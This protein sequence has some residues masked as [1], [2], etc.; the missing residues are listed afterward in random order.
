MLSFILFLLELAKPT[1][2]GPVT[3][4]Q[5]VEFL[6]SQDKDSSADKME[7]KLVLASTLCATSKHL[8]S[9]I[10]AKEH[11]LNEF[12]AIQSNEL[13]VWKRKTRFWYNCAQ[14][15]SVRQYLADR[16]VPT[17]VFAT[18][19]KHFRPDVEDSVSDPELNNMMV[20]FISTVATGQPKIEKDIAAMLK[21][22]LEVACSNDGLD[23]LNAIVVPL[24][25]SEETVPVTV[26]IE[27][28][29]Q[30]KVEYHQIYYKPQDASSENK[31][32]FSSSILSKSQENAMMRM[33]K[34]HVSE[35]HDSYDKLMQKKWTLIAQDDS[36][37]KGDF[38]K[39]SD[40]ISEKSNTLHLIK[41]TIN[42][43]SAVFGGFCGAQFPNLTGLQSDY[44]YELPHDESNFTFYYKGD[45]ENHFIMTNN[46]PFGYIYTDYELGGVISIS[47]DFVL[48][49]WSI[50]YSHTAGNIYN[51][52][53][54]EQPGFA[55][56][57]NN[58]Q[59][60]S[61][62]CWHVDLG[63]PSLPNLNN[64]KSAYF[65]LPF[66]K[67]CSPFNL[68]TENVVFHVP[69]AMK[70]EVLSCE[71]FGRKQKLTIKGQDVEVDLS[72]SIGETA[73]AHPEGFSSSMF[74][75][76]FTRP[77]KED[78]QSKEELKEVAKIVEGYESKYPILEKF[79]GAEE[80]IKACQ[81]AVQGWGNRDLR[82]AWSQWLI[83]VKSF[84]S[85]P[86]FFTR[87]T[88]D[89]NNSDCFFKILSGVPDR[90]TKEA[91]K[92]REKEI[93]K[94]KYQYNHK[95]AEFENE[96]IDKQLEMVKLTYNLVQRIFEEDQDSEGL[97]QK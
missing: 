31:F 90:D 61:Y 53:C 55:S 56:F 85:F 21:E 50:N 64:E 23:Y 57:Y 77:A 84:I 28:K 20:N 27:E 17:Q 12:L 89:R 34:E 93:E 51:M 94:K 33:F 58:I 2:N 25:H 22:D 72:K 3:L 7:L 19:R 71:L 47:G 16:D 62:E 67:S 5:I 15:N 4:E 75:L 74:E 14:E 32:L 24:L 70:A 63:N 59:V 18:F 97:R 68:L 44:N 11:L 91:L 83:E 78:E 80:L 39:I 13:A 73:E 81:K 8:S 40:K 45:M 49:S 69:K 87:L 30:D 1:D 37:K 35:Y 92:K 43:E 26:F 36:P 66:Y 48:C 65:S 46:K 60:E 76:A 86:G 41:C 9:I 88:S 96:W 79:D 10:L 6:L 52:K 95:P 42:G 38:Q 54:V 29:Q 82:E